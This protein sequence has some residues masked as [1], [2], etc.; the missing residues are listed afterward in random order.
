MILTWVSNKMMQD[1]SPHCCVGLG[2]SFLYARLTYQI[3][4]HTKLT[5]NFSLNQRLGPIP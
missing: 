2:R 4:L 1:P 3:E 5:T